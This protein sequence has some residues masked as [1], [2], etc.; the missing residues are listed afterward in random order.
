MDEVLVDDEEMGVLPI[1]VEQVTP[2]APP[3]A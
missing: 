2:P 3:I 1:A